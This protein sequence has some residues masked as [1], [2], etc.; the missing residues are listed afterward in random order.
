MSLSMAG[1]ET[2]DA[3]PIARQ[4]D[5][6]I[7]GFQRLNELSDQNGG[8]IMGIASSNIADELSRFQIW[9]G[10]LGAKQPMSLKSSL[11]HRVRDA[12]KLKRQIVELLGDLEE[13]LA[14]GIHP[15]VL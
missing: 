1:R 5:V 14:D 8:I 12:P 9:V 6:C 11:E 10:N 3:E 7:E 4:C 2:S 13:V 15:P